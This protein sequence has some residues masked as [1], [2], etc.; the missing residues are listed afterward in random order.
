MSEQAPLLR[1]CSLPNNPGTKYLPIA[2]A[3]PTGIADWRIFF[4]PNHRE[5][6]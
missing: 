6:A 1:V 3:E 2:L 5:T 4:L